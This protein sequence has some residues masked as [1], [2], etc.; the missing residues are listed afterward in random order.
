MQKFSGFDLFQTSNEL[1]EL[2]DTF[3]ILSVE[4]LLEIFPMLSDD[5]ELD[6]KLDMLLVL[7]DETLEKEENPSEE[8]LLDEEL[9][10]DE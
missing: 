2:D 3:P 7:N 1:E 4:E 10:L 5:S 6:E 9:L 8:K